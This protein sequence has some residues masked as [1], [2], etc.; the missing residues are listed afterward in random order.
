MSDDRPQRLLSDMRGVRYGEVLAVHA[1]GD[2]LFAEVWGTQLL[3]DCPADWWN[4]LNAGELAKEMGAL[5]VKLNGPRYWTLDG[6]GT[7]VDVVEPVIRELRGMPMRRIAEVELGDNPAA[8]PYT[9][10][11]VNRG[12][13]FFFDAG[14]TV[15]E[16]V[17][18]RGRAFVMQAYCV[19]VDSTLTVES[20]DSLGQRLSLPDGWSFRTRTLDEDLVVDTTAHVATVVQDELEN[21]YTLP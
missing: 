3:H 19:G 21:T 17:D 13:V 4:S 18:P 15:H 5:M 8:V 14:R 20:L 16:L 11:H 10:R 1:R 6:F 9:E 2:K 7:K 12:A